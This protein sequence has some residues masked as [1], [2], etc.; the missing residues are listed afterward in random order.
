MEKILKKVFNSFQKLKL[1][2]VLDFS[3]LNLVKKKLLK[4]N[5]GEIVRQAKRSEVD[6]DPSHEIYLLLQNI[7][8]DLA[9]EISDLKELKDYYDKVLGMENSYMP[10]FPPMSS[11]TTSYYNFWLICDFTIGID[12]ETITSILFGLGVVFKFDPLAME[13]L[14]NLSNSYMGFYKCLGQKDDFI[15]LQNILTGE[16]HSVICTSGYEGDVNTIWF[17]RLAPN[18]DT[19]DNYAVTLTTPY[20]VLES[21]LNDWASFF[22][23]QVLAKEK[24]LF[25]KE[26]IKFLKQPN[27]VNYW[28]EYLL[29]A[30]F[31]YKSNVIF[32]KGIPDIRESLKNKVEDF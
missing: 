2:K 30:Y 14:D 16:V 10:S 12:K 15:I 13:A 28:H 11:L 7:M 4:I 18:L 19:K 1:Q 26:C 9:Y 8:S 24:E 6:F 21:N 3:E 5:S 20:V 31:N 17:V 23:R 32:L 22:E 29:D 27:S 25:V